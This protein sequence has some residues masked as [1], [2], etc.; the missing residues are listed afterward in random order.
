MFTGGLGSYALLSMLIGHFLVSGDGEDLGRSLLGFLQL[1]GTDFDY[2]N[3]AVSIVQGKGIIDKKFSWFE[4]KRRFALAVEDPQV[5]RPPAPRP[6]PPERP[7]RRDEA[8]TRRGAAGAREE[9]RDGD[10]PH[11]GNR[12][13]LPERRECS[14]R[15]PVPD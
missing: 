10:L 13:V 1:Y 12:R 15:A 9:H 5:R 6:H 4:P 7:L 8:L 14:A 2:E 3:S 11:R